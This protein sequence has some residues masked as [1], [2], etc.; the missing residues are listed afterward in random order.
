M[1]KVKLL[2]SKLFKH[3]VDGVD[4][5]LTTGATDDRV[6]LAPDDTPLSSF[7]AVDGSRI[8]IVTVESH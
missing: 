7:S 4:L 8:D 5:Y 1:S 3:P 6:P 2:C